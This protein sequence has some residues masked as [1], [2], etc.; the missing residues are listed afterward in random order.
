MRAVGPGRGRLLNAPFLLLSGLELSDTKG[1]GS[2]IQA[3]LANAG[4]LWWS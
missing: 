2:E 4:A 1:Y 3:L